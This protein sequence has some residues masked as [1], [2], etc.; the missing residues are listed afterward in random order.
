M[1][2]RRGTRHLK[3]QRQ[4]EPP[5]C[6]DEWRQALGQHF[7]EV[8]EVVWLEPGAECPFCDVGTVHDHRDPDES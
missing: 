3:K 8:I 4:P 7:G 5:V 1:S 6:P 2:R